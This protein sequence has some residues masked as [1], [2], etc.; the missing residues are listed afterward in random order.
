M[1]PLPRDFAVNKPVSTII[2]PVTF[3]FRS[4]PSTFVVF[5]DEKSTQIASR[6]MPVSTAN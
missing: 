6:A 5:P 1:I 3:G 4:L 2:F